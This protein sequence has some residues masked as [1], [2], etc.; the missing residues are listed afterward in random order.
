MFG[1]FLFSKSLGL[2]NLNDGHGSPSS[3]R[4][5]ILCYPRINLRGRRNRLTYVEPVNM[6][7]LETASTSH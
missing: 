5:Y 3:R 7:G 2:G 6:A 1:K 4:R